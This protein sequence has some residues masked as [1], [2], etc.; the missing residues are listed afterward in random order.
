MLK[1]RNIAKEPGHLALHRILLLAIGLIAV[2]YFRSWG[3]IAYISFTVLYCRNLANLNG[4]EF[5]LFGVRDSPP[6]NL[7]A[8]FLTGSFFL[9]LIGVLLA[10]SFADEFAAIATSWDDMSLMNQR[11][12]CIQSDKLYRDGFFNCN[13]LHWWISGISLL[14]PFV[15]AFSLTDIV[16]FA[17]LRIKV[18]KW[19]FVVLITSGILLI[20]PFAFEIT[21]PGSSYR[22][23][24]LIITMLY[25]SLLLVPILPNRF[26]F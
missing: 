19:Y 24:M 14:L 2:F 12:N 23:Y 16:K 17:Q 5:I 13:T 4:V 3:L 11:P 6:G 18:G 7:Y 21:F 8:S 25:L 20:L 22:I 9:S 1:I 26:S 10:Y 15:F